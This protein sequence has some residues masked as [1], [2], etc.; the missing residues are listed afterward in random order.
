MMM[1]LQTQSCSIFTIEKIDVAVYF[2]ASPHRKSG[3][4]ITGAFKLFQKMAF[5]YW[6]YLVFTNGIFKVFEY[7][8]SQFSASPQHKHMV[9]LRR[10][11]KLRINYQR[12]SDFR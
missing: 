7:L 10:L 12:V 3:S 1:Q 2:I 8:T 5:S 11:A 9:S 6:L 4:N